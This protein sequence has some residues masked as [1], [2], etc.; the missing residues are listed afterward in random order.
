MWL[1]YPQTT[2]NDSIFS[3]EPETFSRPHDATLGRSYPYAASIWLIAVQHPLKAALAKS[4]AMPTVAISEKYKSHY[5]VWRVS[6]CSFQVHAAAV[7]YQNNGT[8]LGHPA[9]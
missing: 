5:S 3:L 9:R 2:N 7:P 8:A 1:V 6:N 4:T